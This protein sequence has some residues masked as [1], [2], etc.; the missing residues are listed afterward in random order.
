MCRCECERSS[1][2]SSSGSLG[3]TRTKRNERDG[4]ERGRR[5][6]NQARNNNK[7]EID[8]NVIFFSGAREGGEGGRKATYVRF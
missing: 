3:E 8:N 1:S 7:A 2:S 5:I 6:M 4:K